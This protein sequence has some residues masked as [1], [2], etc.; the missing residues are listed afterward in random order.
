MSRSVIAVIL[1]SLVAVSPA[2][3]Q[4][5]SN[6]DFDDLPVG[7]NPDC[8]RPAGA[9]FWPDGYIADNVCE[10]APE[11]M[12]I[13]STSSFDP[14]ATGN[15]LEHNIDLTGLPDV[16]IHLPNLFNQTIDESVNPD[17][18]V[19][20]DIW[21]VE[22]G[23]HGG[24]IYVGGD[25]G[26]CGWGFNQDRGP[27]IGWQNDGRLTVYP[28]VTVLDPYPVGVWQTVR[29]EVNLL[30]DDYDLW[31]AQRGD[32]LALLGSDVPFQAAQDHLDRFTV[33]H[34]T[35]GPTVGPSH[36]YIDNLVVSL[37]PADVDGDGIVGINDFL[38]VLAAWGP[39]G[40]PCVEDIDEDGTVGIVDFL[41]VLASWGL[42]S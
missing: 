12:S 21:V 7:T 10:T 31:W 6:G 17:V 40:S 41:Q 9:W 42:C 36:C 22:E 39:C 25:H 3:G 20:F 5:V 4:I 24:N 1:G 23:V 33:V 34:Y 27:Q 11:Q 35:N 38:Q 26:G 2:W 15:S 16:R 19:T 14:G 29:L 30:A 18:I 28:G 8:D 37:C 13:V 32:P